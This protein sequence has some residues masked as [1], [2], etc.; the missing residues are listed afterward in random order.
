MADSPEAPP[1]RLDSW[2]EI[3]AY[4]RRDVTTVQRW[5][6][7]EGMPVHRH[8]H[9]KLGS[10][11]AF[12]A[13][14]DEWARRRR[15]AVDGPEGAEPAA[16]GGD[17]DR[18]A[19][20]TGGA[21][22]ATKRSRVILASGV[23]AALALAAALVWWRR[24]IE[25]DNPLEGARFTKLT[26]F[27]GI[28][29][30]AAISRDGR[31]AA[32]Q[33]DR[34][35]RMDVWM[36][37]IG[38]GQFVNLT[39]GAVSDLV[40]PS[41]R[42]LGFSPDGTL[43]TFWARGAGGAGR[44]DISVW[45]VPLLGGPPRPYLED[46][47]EYAWTPD[48][49]RLVYHSAGPGDPLFLRDSGRPGPPREIFSAPAGLHGHF[50]LWSPDLSSL[51]LVLGT[52]PDR[53]DVWRLG[54]AGGAPERVTF[55]NGSVSHPVFV[56]AH[57]LLYLA[58]EPDGS[59]PFVFSLRVGG[60]SPR[61][62]SAGVDTYASLDASED[63]R[64]LVATVTSPKR[65]L[66]RVPVAGGRAEMA[67]ARRVPLTTSDGASPRLGPG[68]LL[69][70]STTGARD[71]VWKLEGGAAAEIWSAPSSHVLGAP[72]IR[73]DGRRLALSVR[74]GA[75]TSLYV[76]NPDGT[77]VRAV[78]AGLEPHGAPAWTADGQSLVV[79][80]V[81]DGV[82]RLHRV[83]PDGGAPVPLVREHAQDPACSPAGALVAYSGPDV[84]TA[85]PVHAVRTDGGAPSFPALTLPRGGRHVVFTPDGRS[86]VVLRRETDGNDLWLV[87]L[88]TG[89]ER[90]MTTLPPDFAVRDFDLSPDGTE[91]VLERT[92]QQAD[93]VL[94]ERPVR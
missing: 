31:F 70:V 21:A 24:T 20:G 19:A 43:V 91:L 84:G 59:G 62:V 36:T 71:A 66:W 29:Q 72:A 51:Y 41:V 3:A 34:D 26:D 32:F 45:A 74:E 5:E 25:P 48:G 56:D 23:V 63:G 12:R 85:I 94:I 44:S 49:A 1:G 60:G 13:E 10:V 39:H 2:K 33:S 28:E 11:Y 67:A 30:A 65:T 79:A 4:L 82:P 61:R 80:A 93:V 6:K 16:A 75:R 9:D 8:R 89:A 35:G 90:R 83:A 54:A 14:L 78:G 18:A 47:A 92:Q 46:A 73:R 38:T 69:Y 37:Q 81:T 87:D 40:N 53:M 57:R 76:L 68:Y 15:I 22:G 52:P 27:D 42:A 86:L 88:A 77:D 50:P 7:R 64:R 55:H 17:A 58:T